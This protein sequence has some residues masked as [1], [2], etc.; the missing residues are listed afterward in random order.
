MEEKRISNLFIVLISIITLLL[1]IGS[2]IFAWYSNSIS[3][4]ERVL[5]TSRN[6]TVDYVSGN[7]VT[8]KNILPGSSTSYIFNVSSASTA[9]GISNYEITFNIT[10]NNFKTGDI[11]YKVT[12]ESNIAVTEGSQSNGLDTNYKNFTTETA[13]TITSSV[14]PNE[15]KMYTLIIYYTSSATSNKNL[16]QADFAVKLVKE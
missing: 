6:L 14:K 7:K 11:V 1:V 4:N 10:S 8:L 2:T 9:T 16:L 15:T 12:E 13:T 3:T 5:T